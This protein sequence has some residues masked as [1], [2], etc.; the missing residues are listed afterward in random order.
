MSEHDGQKRGSSLAAMTPL[1]PRTMSIA[2]QTLA[3]AHRPGS[4]RLVLL[5]GSHQDRRQWSAVMA[6][7]PAPLGLLVVDLPGHGLSPALP[8]LPGIPSYARMIW[9]VLDGEPAIGP[10]FVAGHSLGGMI[11]M[12]MGRQR[13]RDLA[14]V[15]AVEGWPHH[16]VAEDAFGS[17][18]YDTLSPELLARQQ[19]LRALAT[20]HLSQAQRDQLSSIWRHWDGSAWLRDTALPVLTL[21]GDRGRPRPTLA[22]LHLPERPGISIQ[23][24]AGASHNLPLERPVAV[25]QAITD[26]I[27]GLTQGHSIPARSV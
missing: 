16:Q 24:Q 18:M 8:P 1:T 12:E 13:P 14:G 9:E 17:R 22:Q 27:N 10:S 15:I 19:H 2:G 21:W 25:A 7:L 6:E 4:P 11:A 3:Y 5:P 20:G 26:Y 23:W